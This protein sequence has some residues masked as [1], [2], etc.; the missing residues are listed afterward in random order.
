MYMVWVTEKASL[1]TLQKNILQV[2]YSDL[3]LVP[4]AGNPDG[5]FR[6]FSQSLQANAGTVA[7]LKITH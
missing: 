6:D 7:Y 1:N 5:L 4:E 3:V 2:P